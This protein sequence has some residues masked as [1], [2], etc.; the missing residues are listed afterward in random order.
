M[1]QERAPVLTTEGHA[2]APWE[3]D[4]HGWE[5]GFKIVGD[6]FLYMITAPLR[7]T[8]EGLI[9]TGAIGAG[10]GGFMLLDK[11][12]RDA[13]GNHRHDRLGEYAD[14]VSQ[15]GNAPV[16]LGLNVAG[17][18]A[19]ELARNYSGDRTHVDAA[20]AATEAQLLAI[21]LSEG[22]GYATMRST[23]RE[24]RDPFTFK[25][26]RS[27]FPSSHVTQTFAVATVL[28]DRYGW[29]VGTVAYAAATAVG[30]ARILQERHWSSDVVAGAALGW[31]VG[32]TVSRRR[33]EDPP[34][35]NFF[36]FVDPGTRT[37]G[38]LMSHQF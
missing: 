35:L 38:L 25:L 34:Y 21:V 15:L 22:I 4:D 9:V 17:I 36:P 30:A 16:L 11:D 19:G 18:L 13:A 33:T 27:S 29:G 14:G 7:P 10:V 12:I 1:A 24:S 2:L 20:L 28:E 23:P 5:R 26:G 3:H 8:V 37:Y 31:L 6:D 32:W